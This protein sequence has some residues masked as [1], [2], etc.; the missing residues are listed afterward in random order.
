MATG[1]D[2]NARGATAKSALKS[3]LRPA[4][5][6]A[7]PVLTAVASAQRGGP[8]VRW[9]DTWTAEMDAGLNALPPF[10]ECPH[11]LYRVLTAPT[12]TPKRHAL[13]C[14]NGAPIA[15]ISLRRRRHHW[16]PVTY[17]C[18]P[19]RIAPAIDHAALGRAL[20]ALGVEIHAPAGIGEEIAVLGARRSW[21]YQT[22]RIDLHSDLEAYWRSKKRLHTVRRAREAS[23]GLKSRIDGDGDLAWIVEHWRT[24]WQDDASNETVCAADRLRFWS[25][26]MGDGRDGVLRVRTLMLLQDDAR[27]SGWVFTSVGDT[28]MWQCG[29]RDPAFDDAKARDAAMLAAIAWAQAHGFRY[30]DLSGGDW[31]RYWGPPGEV[32]HGA[33]FRPRLLDAFAWAHG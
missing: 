31:K 32:R 9:S 20:N 25:A 14:E 28:V 19:K 11:D 1:G 7:W 8:Q 6:A 27:V 30:L 33:I 10:P 21:S 16:E 5:K 23:V 2:Q 13:V 17:Q 15:Q 4:V 12:D 22:Y 24:Q 29:A 18:L 3:A 26:A